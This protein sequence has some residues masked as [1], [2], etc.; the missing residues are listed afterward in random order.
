[1]DES[2]RAYEMSITIEKADI[3]VLGHVNN[4]VYLRWVQEAAVAHWFSA[5]PAVD[6]AR[7][8]WIVLRH[9]IDYKQPARLSDQI[10]V[11][12]WVGSATRVRFERFT[13]VLRAADRALLAHA[14]TLWCSID[15]QTLRPSPVSGEVRAIFSVE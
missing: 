13:D 9:E 15:A 14:R 4:V 3:D 12:T 8:R 10:V 5:A 6:Q 1:M 11:R 2:N 7:I